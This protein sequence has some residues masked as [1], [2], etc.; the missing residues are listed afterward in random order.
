MS[1]ESDFQDILTNLNIVDILKNYSEESRNIIKQDIRDFRDNISKNSILPKI[2]IPKKDLIKDYYYAGKCRNANIARWNGE[3]FTHW[4]EKFGNVFLEDIEYWEEGHLF[5][6]FIP[7]F[8]IG[9]ELPKEINC[10][11]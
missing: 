8:S 2:M 3:H 4:R 7:I 10:D 1:L 9:P 5:D 6:E 11:H